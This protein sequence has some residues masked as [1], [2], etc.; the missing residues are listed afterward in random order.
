MPLEK[1]V[2]SPSGRRLINSYA[3]KAKFKGE[4]LGLAIC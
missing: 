1:Q 2:C 4:V 3:Q